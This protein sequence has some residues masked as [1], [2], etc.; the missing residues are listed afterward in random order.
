VPDRS[1][2]RVVPPILLPASASEPTIEIRIGRIDVRAAIA[3]TTPPPAARV[4]ERPSDGLGA[5]LG[6]RTRGA[7]S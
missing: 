4:E 7:R 6:R 2:L 1:A 5:Y 3:Q